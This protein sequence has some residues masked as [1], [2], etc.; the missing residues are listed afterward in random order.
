MGLVLPTFGDCLTSALS[1]PTAKRRVPSSKMFSAAFSSRAIVSP[2]SQ[3]HTR[4]L[5]CSVLLTTPQPACSLELGNQRS[6]FCTVLPRQAALYSTW[7]TNSE[8]AASPSDLPRLPRAIPLTF[9]SSNI[10]A[11]YVLTMR[12]E[13]WCSQLARRLAIRLCRRATAS[14]AFALRTLPFSQRPSFFCALA[15]LASSDRKNLGGT[16]SW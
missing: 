9:R 16:T 4:S 14:L 11:S 6:I 15:S 1:E 8:S 3:I 5:R 2:H 10:T 12:F 7:R 13:S